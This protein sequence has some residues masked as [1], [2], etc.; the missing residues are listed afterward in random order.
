MK[1]DNRAHGLGRP[2][3]ASQHDPEKWKPVFG[4]DHAPTQNLADDL[5]HAHHAFVFVIDRVTVIDKAPDDYRIGEGNDHLQR[6]RTLISRRRHRECVPQA[7]VVPPGA[8]DFRYQERRLVDVKAVIL[9]VGI[10][11]RPFLGSP[12]LAVWSMRSSSMTRPSIMNT[13]RSGVFE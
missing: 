13:L 9:L 6:A 7:I 5:D 8:A 2:Q 10:D 12:S 4:E 11:D 3:P 1:S